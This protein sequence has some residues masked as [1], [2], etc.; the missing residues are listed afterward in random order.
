MVIG[1]LFNAVSFAAAGFL[2]KSLD[3]GKY[4]DEMKRHNLAMENLA[5]ARDRW[6]ENE[7]LLTTTFLTF[8]CD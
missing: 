3:S 2:F 4:G 1:G 8:L 5:R 7:L 6:S